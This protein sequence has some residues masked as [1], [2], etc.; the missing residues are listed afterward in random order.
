LLGG[1]FEFSGVFM[2][3]KPLALAIALAFSGGLYAQ[4]GPVTTAQLSAVSGLSV[5]DTV[6]VT[7]TREKS[8]LSLAPSS[9]GVISEQ[10]IKTTGP[11]HPKEILSQVPGAAIAVTNGEGHTTNIRNQFTTA[12]YYLYLED[13]IPTR[14]TGFFNHNALYEVNIPQ[15]AGIEVVKGPG[16]ALYGSDALS[17]MVNVLTRAPSSVSELQLSGE[18]G[19]FGWRRLLVDGTFG[20]GPD[21]ALRA[22]VNRTHTDG[23]R[24]S[25]AYDR[26]SGSFRQDQALGEGALLKTILGITHIDQQTGANSPLIYSDY[27]NNPTKNNMA[28]AF[29]KVDAVRLST[30]YEKDFGTSLFT[31]TPYLRSNYM[32]LNG[33]FNLSS[34]PR[35]EKSD[36]SSI[37][38][39]A[40]WRKDFAGEHKTRIIMGL[41]MERSPGTRTEDGLIL[42]GTGTGADRNY[43]SYTTDQR[44]YDYKVTYKSVSPYFHSEISPTPALRVTAGVRYDSMGYDMSN[45]V[46]AATTTEVGSFGGATR[47]YGQVPTASMDYSHWSPKLGATYALSPASSLYTSLNHGFRVPSE[48]QLFRAGSVTTNAVDAGN[49]AQLALAL[50]PIKADQL[51]AGWR[52]ANS[53]WSYDLTVYKLVL[54]DDLVTQRDLATNVTTN[55]NAGKTDHTGIE[56]SLGKA[57]NKQWRFDTALTYAVHRYVDWVTSTADFSGNEMESAPRV[58]AN[59]RLTWV[60][61]P[62]TMAQ[63]E[64]VNM[65]SYWLEQSNSQT[66]GKYPGHDVF[67]LRFSQQMAARTSVFARLMNLTDVRYADSASV[68]SNTPVYSPALPRALYLGLETAW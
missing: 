68:S 19:S 64:W 60:P 59:T 17:G 51:E 24:D 38:M 45:N 11:M 49:R 16:S 50:K 35:I 22:A 41:D 55:V 29:R 47:I 9:V 3:Q 32:G 26:L 12:P 44:I 61:Q 30:Q 63:L 52:G 1:K 15:A 20:T 10:D 23:W 62:G 54:T 66:F 4:N 27:I 48:S 7:G 57:A 46:T 31:V 28:I 58:M 42:S 40:K 21:G 36:V 6:T 8:P 13:G 18:V 43:T 53:G 25:T 14:A 34:D 37:G 5:L 65:G 67:N 2:Y 56:L 39:Q 33:T